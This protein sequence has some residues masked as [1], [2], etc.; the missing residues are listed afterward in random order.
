MC[1][2]WTCGLRLSGHGLHAGRR[3][4]WYI[5]TLVAITLYTGVRMYICVWTLVPCLQRSS[6][7][8]SMSSGSQRHNL[9]HV[10]YKRNTQPTHKPTHTVKCSSRAFNILLLFLSLHTFTQTPQE[11][12]LCEV[13][14]VKLYSVG[15]MNRLVQI[16]KFP[17]ITTHTVLSKWS[18]PHLFSQRFPEVG[19]FPTTCTHT[20][21][22][23]TKL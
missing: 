18:I 14:W 22:S 13:F 2:K 10:A 8:S 6:D 9:N 15:V 11:K 23:K 4:S 5:Y 12:N 16:K 20:S 3:D 1:K 7:E 19:E 17:A 21:S